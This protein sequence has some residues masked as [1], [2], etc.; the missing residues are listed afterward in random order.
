MDAVAVSETPLG[1]GIDPMPVGWGA[2]GSGGSFPGGATNRR[3]AFQGLDSAPL[4][5]SGRA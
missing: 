2:E 4:D 3:G 5:P 1:L